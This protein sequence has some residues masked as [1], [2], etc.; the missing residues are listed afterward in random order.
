M[1]YSEPIPE[2]VR[3]KIGL[4]AGW[5]KLPV[6]VAQVLTSQGYDVHCAAIK[7]H[8]DPVL[9]EIC[10]RHQVFGMARMGGQARFLRSA[11][12]TQATM[13]GKIFKTLLFKRKIDLIHHFPD[14]TFWRHF[15]PVFVS[16]TKD[17]RD[18]TLLNTV[19]ELYAA[20]G[21]T[22]FPATD[23]APE[24]LVKKG[25]LTRKLPTSSQLKDIEF[26]WAMAKEI[27]RLDIGQTVIVKD[28][29]VMAVEAI[30]GTD[31]CIRRAGELCKGGFTV[32]KV[33]KPNQDMRFDVPTIGVETI[34]TIHQAGGS[35][36]A[37]EAD[38]TIVLEQS[39]FIAA[40]ERLGISVI[41]FDGTKQLE[42]RFENSSQP[43]SATI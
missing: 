23:F 34:E 31:Q 14:L 15:Y 1:S 10:Y 12:I 11:G 43:A 35:V 5:G 39:E 7:N 20:S 36:L 22:F 42:S 41:A 38:R 29:A 24:L 30:E 26:G 6:C 32:V 40:A 28:Q 8:A 4:V 17:Q 33:A 27:G 16:R 18:D 3:P 9:A 25:S 37:I 2:T 13:A 21:I 19:V